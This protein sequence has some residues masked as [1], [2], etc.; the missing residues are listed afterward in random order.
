MISPLMIAEF[1]RRQALLACLNLFLGTI[2]SVLVFAFFLLAATMVFRWIGTK[3][4][5]DLPAGIALACVVLVF[6]FGILEHRRG[7]GHREFH[8]SDL[9]PGFDLSTGSG[10]WANA[11]VQEV[12][13]PAYLVSQVCLA[14]PLQFLRAISRLQSRLPDSPDLEQRLASLLEIVNR[15]SGWHPIRHYDDRA[16]EIGYLIR[17]EKIQFSPRKG[18][19]RSL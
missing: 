14:A 13:A 3:P 7:G 10:Y 16:E 19:V 9:Y 6:V 8:E 12:T 1:N 5:P 15:T 18:T 11:Q 2:A 17:M 4:H